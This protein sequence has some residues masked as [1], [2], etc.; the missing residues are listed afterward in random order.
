MKIA[1]AQINFVCIWFSFMELSLLSHAIF[2]LIWVL[3]QRIVEKLIKATFPTDS[4]GNFCGVGEMSDYEFVYFANAPQIVK[5][6]S[7]IG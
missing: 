3:S 1:N 6:L 4:E 7:I 5:N 2:S